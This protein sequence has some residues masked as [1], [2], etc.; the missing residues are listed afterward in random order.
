MF[1]RYFR[2]LRTFR[3]IYDVTFIDLFL[4]ILALY[5]IKSVVLDGNATQKTR[6]ANIHSFKTNPNIRVMI[7]SSVGSNG[8]NL[9]QGNVVIFL[10][11]YY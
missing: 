11:R 4:Q 1:V 2:P 8:L 10:V 7:I 9:T 3:H 6:N 5:G